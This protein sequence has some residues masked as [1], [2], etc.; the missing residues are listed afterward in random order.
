MKPEKKKGAAAI[1]FALILPLLLLLT[2]GIIEFSLILYDKAMITNACREGARQ[3]IVYR[4]NSAGDYSPLS[5]AEI[6][7]VVNNYLYSGGS[8][9]LISLGADNTPSITIISGAA[10]TGEPLLSVR[11]AYTYNFLVLPNF[12]AFFPGT[13]LDGTVN[14]ISES[15]MRMEPT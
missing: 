8:L 12:S 5:A 3:G 7:A 1:E 14:L 13:T 6:E 10:S 11:V 4:T 15:V 2:F 9:R